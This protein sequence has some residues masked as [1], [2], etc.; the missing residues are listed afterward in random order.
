MSNTLT[1]LVPKILTEAAI[2]YRNNSITANL[3]NRGFDSQFRKKGDTINVPSFTAPAV[4]NVTAGRG[5]ENTPTDITGENVSITLNSW[6]EVK[7]Q[8][9]DLE[10]KKMEDGRPSE[11]LEKAVIALA[12]HVDGFILEDMALKGYS[13]A[14]TVGAAFTDPATLVDART[15]MG[16]SNVPMRNRNAS[17]NPTVAGAFIKDTNL[18]ESDKFGGSEVLRDAIVGRLYGYDIAETNNHTDFVGGTLSDG[19]SKDALIAATCAVGATSITFDETTLT[20]TLIEGDIFTK[21]G[22]T[23]EYVV[24]TGSTA[25]GNAITVSFLPA[26]KVSGA[27]GDAVTFVDDYTA[28]GL[29]FQE[30]AYIFGSAP[31]QIDFSGGNIVES[32]TDPATLVDARTKM[33]NSNVPMRNRNASINPTVAG[34]FIKDTNLSESDK[35][36]GSEVLRDAIVGRLY[37]YDIAE[38]NNHTDFVG[39]TLS[40]GTSKDALI[41][42]TCAVGATSITFDETT[43]TGTLIEGDIFTKAGDTQEYVVTTGSTAS[44]NAITVSFLPANKVSG[45]DGDAVTFVDDYTA[46]GL[47][48]QEDAYIFGSAPVQIDFSGGNIVESFTDPVSGVTFTYEVERV[49]KNTEHSLSIL[50]GGEAL[51][52]EGIVRLLS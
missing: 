25:S 30:D 33:G 21:A 24:T 7:I 48:F 42:A 2:I 10:L 20:G 43:L 14:G 39:G 46:A 29:A 1:D 52:R 35:F 15:K 19:T 38:T 9:T 23:Q 40:D 31:V 34:A 5:N 28:A 8:F 47:A 6:K 26:N 13:T 16:N 41:A 36:G 51:K 17:I 3:I 32:F 11:A 27:D 44:G 49:N 50:Y 37:G 4:Q 12:D 18:S 22:D 45:A